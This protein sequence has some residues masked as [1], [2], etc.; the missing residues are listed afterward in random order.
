MGSYS[1]LLASG[2]SFSARALASRKSF[3]VE[4]ACNDRLIMSIRRSI[5]PGLKG[6]DLILSEFFFVKLI[7]NVVKF[8][9]AVAAL[10]GVLR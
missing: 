2:R 8:G 9:V 7:F 5:V 10:N 3:Y 1:L 4:E 6:G